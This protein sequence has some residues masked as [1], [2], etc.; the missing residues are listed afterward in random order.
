M[1]NETLDVMHVSMSTTLIGYH[2][3]LSG[4]TLI[5]R[6]CHLI[7]SSKS[8]LFESSAQL[9]RNR[10]LLKNNSKLYILFIVTRDEPQV[11]AAPLS[12]PLMAS[13]LFP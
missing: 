8:L 12:G 9:N 7:G 4:C 10:E 6:P 11:R 1:N 3:F 2:E 13:F 5:W